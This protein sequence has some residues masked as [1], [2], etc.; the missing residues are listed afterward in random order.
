MAVQGRFSNGRTWIEY[1]AAAL[2]VVL[3]GYEAVP[4]FCYTPCNLV[5]KGQQDVTCSKYVTGTL[6]VELLRVPPHPV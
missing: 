2:G 5:G 6:W 3:E 1:A 4:S